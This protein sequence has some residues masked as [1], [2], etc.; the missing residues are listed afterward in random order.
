MLSNPFGDEIKN[1]LNIRGMGV[2]A[3]V[4]I[5]HDSYIWQRQFHH[6]RNGNDERNGRSPTS[7]AGSLSKFIRER[8]DS[9]RQSG[10]YVMLGDSCDALGREQSVMSYCAMGESEGT[11]QIP[12]V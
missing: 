3:I 9:I 6:M 8:R 10:R 5:E 12:S 1:D 4:G 11:L 2:A 7:S